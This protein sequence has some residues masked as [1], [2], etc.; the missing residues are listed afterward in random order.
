MRL[1]NV[2]WVL[3]GISVLCGLAPLA[4]AQPLTS[5]WLGVNSS[6]VVDGVSYTDNN[7]QISVSADVQ[8][9]HNIAVGGQLHSA[10][11]DAIR[12]RHRG[13]SAYLAYDKA[14]GDTWLV[15]TSLT[16][17]RFIDGAKNWNYSHV[18]TYIKHDSGVS[19]DM[20]YSPRYYATRFSARQYSLSYVREVGSHMYARTRASHFE[21]TSVLHYQYMDFALG[22][23]VRRLNIEVGYHWVSDTLRPTPIGLVTSPKWQLRAMY[24]LF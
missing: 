19:V 24:L 10:Q 1:F 8:L 12:Q 9:H 16:H 3:L 20:M 2:R 15:G 23:N 14:L 18:N 5:V 7:T 17:R 22:M 4:M 13:F 21:L 6:G 11:P